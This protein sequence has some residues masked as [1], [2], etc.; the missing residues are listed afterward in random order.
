MG[1]QDTVE[2]YREMISTITAQH[3]KLV[4]DAQQ[5]LQALVEKHQRVVNEEDP[6]SAWIEQDG[7]KYLLLNAQA[8]KEINKLFETLQGVIQ[9]MRRGK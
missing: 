3:E 9:T 1:I 2:Q 4:A 6:S 5:Q 8:A 7:Q